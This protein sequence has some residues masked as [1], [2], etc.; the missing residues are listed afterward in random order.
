MMGRQAFHG[1]SARGALAP[2]AVVA[3]FWQGS[4]RRT[5]G[6]KRRA[7]A[8]RSSLCHLANARRA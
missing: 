4:C 8:M 2:S 7:V 6:A 5:M 3:M 1:C